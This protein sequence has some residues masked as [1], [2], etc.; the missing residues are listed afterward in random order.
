[1]T[2]APTTTPACP[3]DCSPT[4][5]METS[6]ASYTLS[7]SLTPGETKLHVCRR[8][9]RERV[10]KRETERED[11]EGV[12]GSVFKNSFLHTYTMHT[13]RCTRADC[14]YLHTAPR[15]LSMPYS[16]PVVAP[17][18]APVAPMITQPIFS[19]FTSRVSYRQIFVII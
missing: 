15:H 10:R 16:S 7:A 9:G 5:S 2:P 1:V 12:Y 17:P 11:L 14:P 19:P 18:P 8:R 6:A 4:A 3:V 13:H